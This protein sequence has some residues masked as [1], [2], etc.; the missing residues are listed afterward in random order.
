MSAELIS[1]DPNLKLETSTLENIK[2]AVGETVSKTIEVTIIAPIETTV[3]VELITDQ[4]NTLAVGASLMPR[5]LL[6]AD[7][8]GKAPIKIDLAG[9]EAVTGSVRR[10]GDMLDLEFRVLDSK[11][12]PLPNTPHKGSCI[13]LF[14]AKDASSPITQFF[15]VPGENEGAVLMT[16]GRHVL[17][18]IPVQSERTQIDYTARFSLPAEI[19]KVSAAGSFLFDAI[20]NLGAL[21]DAHSGGRTC[22]G[23]QFNSSVSSAHYHEIRN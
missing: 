18:T 8:S 20:A 5:K 14:F 7:S 3:E 11:V 13:E 2:V 1:S 4:P 21:G 10:N 17:D 22:L 6:K 16:V 12:K 23:G 15:L 19:A 9:F